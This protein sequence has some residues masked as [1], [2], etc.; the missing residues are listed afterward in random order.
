MGRFILPAFAF[1]FFPLFL[2]AACSP[3]Q[4]PHTV[5]AGIDSFGVF[6]ALGDTL[7]RQWV[8]VLPAADCCKVIYDLSLAAPKFSGSG[9]FRLVTTLLTSDELG[10][11]TRFVYEGQWT[12]LRGDA[13]DPDATVYQLNPGKL[14]SVM[15]FRYDAGGDSLTMLAPGQR[16]IISTKSYT[17]YRVN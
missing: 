7:V 1:L 5:S 3:Q 10:H 15:D 9:N 12:T 6:D 13:T 2:C 14:E 17:L 8:G 11:H 4:K 16:P